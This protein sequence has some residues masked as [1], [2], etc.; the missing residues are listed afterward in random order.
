MDD[1]LKKRFNKDLLILQLLEFLLE[2]LVPLR[3]DLR[4]RLA[5]KR[6]HGKQR[7]V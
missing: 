5:R 2:L 3:K 1:S 6:T 4:T 7:L